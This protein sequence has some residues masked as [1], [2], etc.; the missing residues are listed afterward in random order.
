MKEAALGAID[1]VS[2]K[3]ETLAIREK[4]IN[5]KAIQL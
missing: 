2:A 4:A 1:H 3:V 5:D